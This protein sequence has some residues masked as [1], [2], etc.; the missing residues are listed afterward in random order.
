MN[1][2]FGKDWGL[3]SLK[4]ILTNITV[5]NCNKSGSFTI[6]LKLAR[7]K[8]GKIVFSAITSDK[9]KFLEHTSNSYIDSVS[10]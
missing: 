3:A 5:I 10:S 7:H 8:R 9:S 4:F 6:S 1:A 2:G